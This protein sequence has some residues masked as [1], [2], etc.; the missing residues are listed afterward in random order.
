ML[1][2]RFDLLVRRQ[3][4]IPSRHQTLREAIDWSYRLLSPRLQALFTRLF[5]FRGGFTAEAAA[6]VCQARGRASDFLARLQDH[7]LVISEGAGEER[8]FR[9]L[10]TLREYAAEQLSPEE[11][12]T[13][14][15]LHADFYLALTLAAA[16]KIAGGPD[17][18]QWLDRLET[19]HDNL[20]AALDWAQESGEAELGLRLAVTTYRSFGTR[21]YS[22]EGRDRITALL[23]LPE[24]AGPTALR[25]EAFCAAGRMAGRKGEHGPGRALCEE[26]VAMWRCL[27]D[28]RGL[29][30][31]VRDLGAVAGEQGDLPAGCRFEEESLILF[32]ALGD[33]REIAVGLNGLGLTLVCC[34]EYD[35]ARQLLERSLSLNRESGSVLGIAANLNNL[36][37]CALRQG[38]LEEATSLFSES[39]W[40]K[41]EMG[42]SPAGIAYGIEG[43]AESAA[44]RGQWER[45]TRLLGAATALH[46]EGGHP[47]CPPSERA[48]DER[49]LDCA[50]Q[51]L[52]ETVF[53]AAW[54][55]GSD[56]TAEQA[57]A[58]AL[59]PP[60]S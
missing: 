25:A 56:M 47:R 30:A 7:S 28:R 18:K 46:G 26:G 31:A 2:R 20:R 21:G 34:A 37:L 27:A 38:C 39:L 60:A 58:Y 41:L 13:V 42:N 4:D 23:R 9:L 40:T 49:L 43:L 8:R 44:A 35:R 32:E 54:S 6:A 11:R 57:V 48:H 10:E 12:A 55:E 29:A 16:P 52:G 59:E 45:A 3:R 33:R 5:V 1:E 36:G 14:A 50:R 17:Q 22:A 51:T 24:A 53:A 15:R 19:E